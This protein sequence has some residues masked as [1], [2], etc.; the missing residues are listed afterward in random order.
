MLEYL[1]PSALVGTFVYSLLGV[2]FM[3]FTFWIIDKLT[4]GELWKELIEHRNQAL[5]T[6]CAGLFIAMAI[7]IAAAIVG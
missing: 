7:I 4:P 6:V 2:L 3:V 1:K 5:A